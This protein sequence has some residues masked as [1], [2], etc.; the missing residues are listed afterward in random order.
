MRTISFEGQVVI[1]SGAGG[2]IGRSYAID[3]ARR[4]GAV[5]VNDLGGD[6]AGNNPSAR[7]AES[8][9]REIVDNGGK[10]VA[11]YDS[12][13]DRDGANAIVDTAL[14]AFGR[15][16][17]LINNAGIMRNDLFENTNADDTDAII[18]THLNGTLN[19]S[20][21]V[22]PHMQKQA[23]GRVVITA[24]SAGLFGNPLQAAYGA[25]KGGVAGLMNVLALEGEQHGI[26]CNAIMPNASGRMADQMTQDM[27]EQDRDAANQL[28]E[29]L[30]RSFDPEFNTAMGVYLASDACT[31][32]HSLYSSCAGRFAHVF[33][34]VSKG[35]QGSRETAAA[36]EDIAE[37]FEDIT[38]LDRGFDLPLSSREEVGIAIRNSLAQED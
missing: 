34:G 4:G 1:V 24:S 25:A 11:N 37:H 21:A 7:M 28:G 36:A 20:Q 16:D 18:A 3:I 38:N 23:Y 19:L 35:W 26:L 10:A 17:A 15:I 31:S 30:A 27:G 29:I 13:A 32:T 14:S 5:V 2:G 9:V 33:V 6:V 8:V 22:W 12:V